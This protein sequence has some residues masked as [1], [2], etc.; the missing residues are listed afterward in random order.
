MRE[1]RP[2]VVQAWMGHANLFSSL[3][4]LVN[5]S[6]PIL[7]NIRQTTLDVP[8]IPRSTRIVDQATVALAPHVP[9]RVV[10]CAQAIAERYAARG[11]PSW[12]LKVIPNGVDQDHL[13]PD[14]DLRATMRRRLGLGERDV[15]FGLAVRNHPQKDIPTFLRAA[16]I[17]AARHPRI[18]FVLAGAGMVPEQ[19]LPLADP[20]LHPRLTCVGEQADI[21]PVIQAADVGV[22][23]SLT[24]GLSNAL[25]EF[26]VAG[27]PCVATDVGDNARVIGDAGFIVPPARPD[28]LADALERML[29]MSVNQRT[30]LGV[31]ARRRVEARYS[32]AAMER[33]YLELWLTIAG[34]RVVGPGQG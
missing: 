21:A 15:V 24:E 10:C 20:S 8:G 3:A 32:L 23:S 16:A 6:I 2:D 9:A 22:L 11:V 12:K 5:R 7:W 25:L 30:A 34:R 4:R 27:R 28:C 31:A 17:V 26:M 33:L 19:I 1:I 18:G 29:S 13:A 14:A